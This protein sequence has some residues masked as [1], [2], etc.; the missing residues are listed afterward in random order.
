MLEENEVS[1]WLVGKYIDTYAFADGRLE[2]RWKGVTLPY[3][4][5]DKDQRQR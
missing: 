5:F 1:R 3:T 4:M 2:M